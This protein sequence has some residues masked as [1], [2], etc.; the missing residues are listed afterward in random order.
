MGIR[1]SQEDLY[2]AGT[3]RLHVQ[4]RTQT[5]G[6]QLYAL[7]EEC[8]TSCIHIGHAIMDLRYHAGGDEIQS[9]A[10]S[11]KQLLQEWSSCLWMLK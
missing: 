10:L 4:V 7:L 1:T 3:P 5:Y 6:G 8:R 9:W 11:L 2:I